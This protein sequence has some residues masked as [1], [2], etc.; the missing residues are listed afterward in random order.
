MN[1]YEL[2]YGDE[3][4]S[5]LLPTYLADTVSGSSEVG[6]NESEN[7]EDLEYS[8]DSDVSSTFSIKVHIHS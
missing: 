5:V 3:D 4:I 8:E 6:E 1:E 7:G 2:L